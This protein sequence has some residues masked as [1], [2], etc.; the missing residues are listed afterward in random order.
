MTN[1]FGF[2]RT[3]SFSFEF[4]HILLITIHNGAPDEVLSLWAFAWNPKPP[5]THF[6]FLSLTSKLSETGRVR[7]T[8][9]KGRRVHFW[10]F[11]AA[12]TPSCKYRA[13]AGHDATHFSGAVV[14]KG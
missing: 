5:G 7:M 10:V 4:A 8:K 11:V 2:S 3:Q 6:A 14:F 1:L 13:T 12:S 9:M